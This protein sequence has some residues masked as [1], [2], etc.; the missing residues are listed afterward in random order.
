MNLTMIKAVFIDIDNTLLSFTEYV[1]SSMRNGFAE[2]EIGTYT[3]DMFDVFTRINDGL[4]RRIEQG[5][6]T[7]Y[8]LK[9]IRWNMIFAELGIDYD[10]VSFETY[11][12]E[13]LNFNAIP[14]QGA[15]EMLEYLAPKYTLCTASN[16]PYDQQINRLRV[17]NM[18]GYF[19]HHFI[20]S[21]IG[22]Q[23]PSKEFFAACF[24]ELKRSG[25]PDILPSETI[26]IG[27]SLTSDIAGGR[28]YGTKTCLYTKKELRDNK[29][30]DY[31]ISELIQ[32][33]NIL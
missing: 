11:F 5:T 19:K 20:S 3:E 4:W 33:K 22:A 1:K 24:N 25:M 28:E 7:L 17:G 21:K 16:G 10:G 8:E 6:L 32:I 26:I 29:D 27:D 31:V 23:K 18:L 13:R 14:E 12:R 15:Y 2:L 30:A 9:K